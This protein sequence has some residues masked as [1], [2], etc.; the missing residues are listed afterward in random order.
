MSS[1]SMGQLCVCLCVFRMTF[2]LSGFVLPK[3]NAFVM[4]GRFQI[5]DVGV[6]LQHRACLPSVLR[7]NSAR[8]LF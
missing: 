7:G 5:L 8:G 4:K 3:R 1:S 6:V 2:S